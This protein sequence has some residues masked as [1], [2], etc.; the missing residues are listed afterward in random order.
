MFVADGSMVGRNEQYG[1]VDHERDLELERRVLWR[2]R[3]ECRVRW[4]HSRQRLRERP[5]V[6]AVRRGF[7]LRDDVPK[8]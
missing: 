7:V 3:C 1:S 6:R 2:E 4:L 5:D 8:W